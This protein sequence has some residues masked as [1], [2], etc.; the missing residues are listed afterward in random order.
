MT[1]LFVEVPDIDA[2]VAKAATLGA[3]AIMP[4]AVLPDGGAVAV[5]LDPTGLTIGVCTLVKR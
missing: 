1:Q 2:R 5:L 3:K 4:K